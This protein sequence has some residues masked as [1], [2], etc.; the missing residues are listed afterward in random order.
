M[1]LDIFESSL[2]PPIGAFR[3]VTLAGLVSQSERH[4]SSRI[5]RCDWSESCSRQ[6]K[7]FWRRSKSGWRQCGREKKCR[8]QI[9]RQ[10][11]SQNSL[12]E[13]RGKTNVCE[14]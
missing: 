4:S 2:V 7:K 10:I 6:M 13:A 11:N 5:R 1:W 14:R 3:F 12:I 9:T 8:Q